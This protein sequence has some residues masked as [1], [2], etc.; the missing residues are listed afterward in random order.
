MKVI[1]ADQWKKGKNSLSCLHEQGFQAGGV[2]SRGL[3]ERQGWWQI[4]LSG[5]AEES[6]P[7]PQAAK[8]C[9]EKR[10]DGRGDEKFK[11]DNVISESFLINMLYVHQSIPV[12][13]DH[14][15]NGLLA[16]GGQDYQRDL[17]AGGQPDALLKTSAVQSCC[18]I[19][20]AG[21]LSTG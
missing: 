19:P 3:G 8:Q 2:R 11:C 17:E 4:P 16:S 20:F 14:V 10:T 12:G 1:F 5:I 18:K 21:K 9:Q 6:E 13:W 15:E 7:S